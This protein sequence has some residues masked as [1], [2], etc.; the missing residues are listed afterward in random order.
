MNLIQCETFFYL[1]T[2]ILQRALTI[3]RIYRRIFWRSIRCL[4][5]NNTGIRHVWRRSF[6]VLS[7]LKFSKKE[8]SK[9]C[10]MKI[11]PTN[12]S[13]F[14]CCLILFVLLE[15]VFSVNFACKES[16]CANRNVQGL[17]KFRAASKKFCTDCRKLRSGRF[18]FRK[19]S[20]KLL[21]GEIFCEDNFLKLRRD[22]Q[23]GTWGQRPRQKN[24][25]GV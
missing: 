5:K 2:V 9:H 6:Q 13:P 15:C 22:V 17:I 10:T 14:F 7:R 12:F 23:C 8:T 3:T 1:S 4:Q 19:G 11:F 24:G 21:P 18:G 20:T 25:E 16:S